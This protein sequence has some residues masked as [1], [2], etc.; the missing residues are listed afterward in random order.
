MPADSLMSCWKNI[1][2]VI[3]VVL[4]KF[5]HQIKKINQTNMKRIVLSLLTIF[6]ISLSSYGQEKRPSPA[7]TAEGSVGATK[8]MI[9]YSSPSMKGRDIYGG[10]V[11]WGKIWRAGAN[12]ATTIEFSANVKINGQELTAGKYAFFV[13]PNEKED[14]V[15]IFNKVHQQW[16]AYKYS[17]SEDALR[18]QAK[19][20]AIDATESLSYKISKD[21][22]VYLDWAESRVGFKVD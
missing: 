11:P 8:V 7:M 15:L 9:N 5:N 4:T 1:H 22:H 16:G 18:V 12:E 13:I 6:L 3:P 10:L 17:K 14:W 2:K 19:S 21:G 20:E